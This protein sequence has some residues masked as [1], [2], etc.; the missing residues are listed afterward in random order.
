MLE[1]FTKHLE[2]HLKFAHDKRAKLGKAL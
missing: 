2:H 1:T